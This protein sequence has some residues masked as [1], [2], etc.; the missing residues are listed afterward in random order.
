M[1]RAWL[2]ALALGLGCVT[3]PPTLGEPAPVVRDTRSEQAYQALL[4]RYTANDEIYSGFDTVLFAAATLQTPAFREARV[5]RQALFQS[6]TA[7]K[8][9][10][11]LAEEREQ[12]GRTHEFLLG[13]HVDNPRNNDFDR[14]N[15]VW[16]VL[17]VTPTA[18]VRPVRVQRLG[19]SSQDLR[20]LYPYLGTF[21]VAYRME[22]PTALEDG[23]PVIPPGTERVSLRIASSLGQ[24]ELRVSAR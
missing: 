17:L 9:E 16:N 21:W 1:S 20:A 22:F 13:V 6:L 18:E 10:A 4:G 11:L 24:V 8:V 3:R 23:T 14:A 15:S 2:L 19:R 7:R 12:A 5:R